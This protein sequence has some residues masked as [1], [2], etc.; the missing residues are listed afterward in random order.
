MTL[1]FMTFDFMTFDYFFSRKDA[2]PMSRD[3]KVF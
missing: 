2:I 1:D 3:A